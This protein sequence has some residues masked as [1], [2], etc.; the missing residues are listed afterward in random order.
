MCAPGVVAA[1]ARTVYPKR[2]DNWRVW[3]NLWGAA[4]APAGSTKS[5]A[6]AAVER[7]LNKL[8]EQARR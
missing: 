1:S 7:V 2:F 8:E 3:T 5:P 4:V 6:A